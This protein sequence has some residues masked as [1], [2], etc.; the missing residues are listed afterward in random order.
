MK[1]L[2][3]AEKD[4][5]PCLACGNEHL[6]KWQLVYGGKRFQSDVE[7]AMCFECVQVFRGPEGAPDKSPFGVLDFRRSHPT[8]EI[9]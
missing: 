7:G 5:G 3:Q 8:W 6:G 9:D 1:P 4:L 2:T